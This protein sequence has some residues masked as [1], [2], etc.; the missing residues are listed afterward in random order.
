MSLSLHHC[1]HIPLLL[2]THLPH[3]HC[4]NIGGL[5]QGDYSQRREW[6]EQDQQD[7]GVA[8]KES[9]SWG[10]G[11]QGA[12]L[13]LLSPQQSSQ[14]TMPA[15]QPIPGTFHALSSVVHDQE[16]DGNCLE[17]QEQRFTPR[18]AESRVGREKAGLEKGRESLHCP[19]GP[20]LLIAVLSS[21]PPPPGLARSENP[22]CGRAGRRAL[23]LEIQ[24]GR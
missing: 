15:L 21:P 13:N 23:G 20:V 12:L 6:G 8:G 1:A 5:E 9:N 22:P 2:S 24:L 11:R 10:S 17:C 14:D 19:P 3:H 16:A 18:A 7:H 4:R